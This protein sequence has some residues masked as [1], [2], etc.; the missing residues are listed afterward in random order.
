MK[1]F[2]K[3]TKKKIGLVLEGGGM[4]GI[5]T[6]GVLDCLMDNDIKADYVIGVSAGAGNGISYI[7][8]QR[9]RG[10]RVNTQYLGDDRYISLKNF[11]KTK[12]VFGMDFIFDIIPNELDHF[13]YTA[14]LS[15]PCE[16]VAGVTDVTT[17]KPVYFGKEDMNHTAVVLR[18]SS[19]L[20]VFS[21]IVEYKGG[22][23]L[24]GGTSDPI[25]VK[26]ALLDGCDK[27]IVI[28]TQHR[29]YVKKPEKYKRIYLHTF[30]NYPKMIALL[31]NRHRIYNHT[32]EFLARLEKAGKAI[33]IAP[34]VPLTVSRFE[35]DINKLNEIYQLGIKDANEKLPQ[36]FHYF[37]K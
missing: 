32:L 24:D 7:S 16:F 30:R 29:G 18:A 15:S 26:K 11:V 23:Y 2:M 1:G 21:P 33:V 25:P 37:E 35:K 17:G 3:M 19:S 28:L 9:G 5:Y 14:F 13:D 12:S 36:I 4:R 22:E 20:P 27:L 34:T 10:Y 6:N 8:N 31:N